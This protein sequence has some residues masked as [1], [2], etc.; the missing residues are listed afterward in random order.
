MLASNDRGY[1]FKS[2]FVPLQSS[3]HYC[4]RWVGSPCGTMEKSQ[5]D[6]TS[7]WVQILP[8]QDG[9]FVVILEE[10]HQTLER[11]Q[12]GAIPQKSFANYK[13]CTPTFT[14]ILLSGQNF[15]TRCG[16][17]GQRVFQ[18]YQRR[19]I[20]SYQTQP[21]LTAV[22]SSKK[23]LEFRPTLVDFVSTK[24]CP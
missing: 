5:P 17:H 13:G 10:L 23:P 19:L 1:G 6:I 12:I 3:S 16:F 15:G 8:W 22:D 21:N 9:A 11:D 7:L 24:K 14:D 20:Y 18:N 2:S 4:I